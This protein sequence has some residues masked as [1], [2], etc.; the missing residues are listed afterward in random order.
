MNCLLVFHLSLV[1]MALFSGYLQGAPAVGPLDSLVSPNPTTFCN[2]LN[3]DYMFQAPGNYREAADPVGLFYQGNYYIFASKS[4]GYW[5]SPDFVH[6]RLVSPPN[7]PLAGWAPAVFEYKGAVYFMATGGGELYKSEH[8]EEAA[9]WT[10]AGAVRTD[11]DPDLF[12]DNDGRV[13]LYYGCHPGGPIRGVELDPRHQ[14]A[15]LGQ[16]V[17]LLRQDLPERGWE[18]IPA[19][20][21]KKKKAKT[22]IEGAWMTRHNGRYYLQ[23]AAPR[24][25]VRD[26]RGRRG[27]GG[28]AARTIRLRARQPHFLQANRFSG[29]RRS[30]R[31]F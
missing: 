2:P 22:Y 15:E 4:E 1:T 18:N 17:E 14:F 20:D 23:Y 12:V 21:L 29:G 7:L 16:P 11:E 13:Y 5:V 3:L 25:A 27:G 10:E 28:P 19:D 6:W 26:L 31:G 30:Q 24:H 9:S 8:P